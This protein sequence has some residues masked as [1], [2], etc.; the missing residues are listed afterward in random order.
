MHCIQQNFQGE[1]LLCFEWEMAIHNI[2]FTVAFLYAYIANWEGH[3][4]QEK[5]SDWVKN[6]ENCKSFP[7]RNVPYIVS[8]KNVYNFIYGFTIMCCGYIG[9]CINKNSFHLATH[10]VSYCILKLLGKI[11]MCYWKCMKTVKILLS[12]ITKFLFHGS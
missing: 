1:K 4:L 6:S 12:R 5:I 8:R 7:L 10:V 2:T 9:I 11:P 3:D